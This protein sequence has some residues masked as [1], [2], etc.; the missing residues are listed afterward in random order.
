MKK[1][2]FLNGEQIHALNET[3][4]VSAYMANFGNRTQILLIFIVVNV[5]RCF[6]YKK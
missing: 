1:I 4:L 6:I 3:L 5:T 2:K